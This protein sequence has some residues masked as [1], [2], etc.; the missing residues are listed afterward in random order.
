MSL[1][2]LAAAIWPKV[3][4]VDDRREEVDRLDERVRVVPPVHTGIVRGPEVHEDP[5]VLRH[6][7]S[8]QDLSELAS[9]E[10]ARST[11]AGDHF[12]QALGHRCLTTMM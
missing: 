11:R 8:A 7:N 5:V 10:F 1:S 2:A 6:G 9:G 3:R 12:G 4:V